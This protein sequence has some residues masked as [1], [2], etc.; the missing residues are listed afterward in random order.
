MPTGC[1]TDTHHR[2]VVGDVDGKV[3]LLLKKVANVI[4]KSGAF[5]VRDHDLMC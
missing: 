5:D 2:L 4:K 1:R 3:K